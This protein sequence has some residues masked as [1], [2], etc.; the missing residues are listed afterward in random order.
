MENR[1]KINQKIMTG[2][3]TFFI[4]SLVLT[5]FN[6][7]QINTTIDCD[8]GFA[9]CFQKIPGAKPGISVYQ[10]TCYSSENQLTTCNYDFDAIAGNNQCTI[11]IYATAYSNQPRV[12]TNEVANI[13]VNGTY[14][15]R[16][17]DGLCDSTSGICNYISE[18]KF[19]FQTE[20]ELQSTNQIKLLGEGS[21]SISH[22]EIRCN[23]SEIDDEIPTAP[24]VQSIAKE[25]AYNANLNKIMNLWNMIEDE[26]TDDELDLELIEKNLT[27]E[28]TCEIESG[29]YLSCVN[30][31]NET[32]EKI[33]DLYATDEENKTGKGTI[34]LLLT[35]KNPVFQ[36]IPNVELTH[37][38][39]GNRIINLSEYASD[40]EQESI[41]LEYR[42]ID[43]MGTENIECEIESNYY[44]SC[45]ANYSQTG[46]KKVILEVKDE[47]GKID[48]EETTIALNESAEDGLIEITPTSQYLSL[49]KNT[50]GSAQITIINHSKEKKCIELIVEPDDWDIEIEQWKQNFCLLGKSQ[51]NK[52]IVINTDGAPIGRYDISIKAEYDNGIENAKI[53]LDVYEQAKEA[54]EIEVID[55]M[56]CRGEKDELRIRIKNTSRETKEISLWAENQMFLPYI[57]R[58]PLRMDP[59]EERYLDVKLHAVTQAPYGRY[60]IM[61]YGTSGT[62]TIQ[63]KIS[64]NLRDCGIEDDEKNIIDLDVRSLCYN[65]DKGKSIE[66]EFF[67]TNLIKERQEVN[68][69]IE[70]ELRTEFITKKIT[71]NS[72]EKQKISMKVYAENQQDF[73]R[74]NVRVYAWTNEDRK[75]EELCVNVNKKAE[76][77]AELINNNLQIYYLGD[78]ETAVLRI[79]NIGD[80]KENIKIKAINVGKSIT[81]NISETQIELN[82]KKEK[83]IYVN[84]ATSQNPDLGNYNMLILIEG[85]QTKQMKLNY[86][87]IETE[88]D[89]TKPLQ[90]LSIPSKIKF[91]RNENKKIIQLTI[92]NNTEKIMNQVQATIDGLPNGVIAKIYNTEQIQQLN[93]NEIKTIDIE[94]E[95]NRDVLTRN[96]FE[97]F[98]RIQNPNYSDV[99]RLDVEVEQN[100]Q[101]N[102]VVGIGSVLTGLAGLL[103]NGSTILFGLLILILLLILAGFMINSQHEFENKQIWLGGEKSE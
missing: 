69:T 14:I 33:L 96:N 10:G 16:T 68:I 94:L 89:Q 31:T 102:E 83:D 71:L 76:F 72:E 100:Q 78:N 85:S 9:G 46:T 99:K 73:G 66:T 30:I 42:I 47:K 38:Q 32:G 92:K 75:I 81:V 17:T 82:P 29:Q 39:S 60:D 12:Q 34:K 101:N 40:R 98:I 25:F 61:I 70:S 91:E 77:T 4:F 95:I 5:I 1:K 43:Q 51:T 23:N 49:E 36:E 7:A 88:I 19:T 35:N 20:Q 52:T 37:Y 15:G 24:I 93:K 90:I 86:S 57:E 56:I 44:L 65:V 97:L 21:F 103:G 13:Y 74:Y 28:I 55:G 53:I 79:K 48:T 58:T 64:F 8:D 59:G 54:F 67:V 41:E 2:L 3:I 18:R 22:I 87:V 26:T 84:V 50:V 80:Y 63:K 6:A 11:E 27:N 62:E 45:T